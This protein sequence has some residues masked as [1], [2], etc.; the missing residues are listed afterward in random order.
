MA[1]YIID[2]GKLTV[3]PSE[4]KK[5][6]FQKGAFNDGYQ[7]GD[8]TKSALSTAADVGVN[9][10][11]GV[12]GLVEGLVD[13][14]AYGV[15]GAADFFG[16][17][18]FAK[19]VKKEAQANSTE[20]LFG[21]IDKKLNK[22]SVLGYYVDAVTEGVGQIGGIMLTGGLGSAAG[23]SG[24]GLSALTAGVMGASSAGA[25]ISEAYQSGAKDKEAFKY[26]LIKGAVDSGTELIFGGIMKPLKI[27]GIGKGL[28]S[29]DDAVARKIS[30]AVTKKLKSETAQRWLG[31][32]VQHAIKAGAEGV[33]EVLAGIGTAYAK[34][35]SYMKKEDIDKLIKDENLFEQFIVGSLTSAISQTGDV[36]RYNRQGRDYVTGLTA[37]EQKVVDKEVENRIAEAKENGKKVNK[38]KIYDRVMTDLDRGYI[39]TDT[40]EEVLGGEEYKTSKTNA[41][42]RKRQI[43]ALSAQIED[44][45]D[46]IN[47][48]PEESEANTLRGKLSI[49]RKQLEKLK[50]ADEDYSERDAISNKVYSLVQN[51]RLGESYRESARKAEHYT[52]D[53]SKYTDAEQKIVQKAIDSGILNNSNR[54]H[55][56]VDFVAKVSAQ[57]GIDFDFAD[58]KKIASSGFAVNGATINGY[59][60]GNNITVNVNSAK[61]LDTVV[62]HEITH[63][64]E[65]TEL[66][67]SLK[68]TITEYAKS[69]G[70]YDS[71]LE[72]IREL[73]KDV[74][75]ADI[76][77]ELTADLIGEY[78]FTDED[79]INRLA[80]NRNLFQKVFDEIKYLARIATAGSSEAK[81]LEKAKVLF[82]KAYNKTND[83]VPKT[84]SGTK[85]SLKA[86]EVNG[87]EHIINPFSITKEDV[88]D[89]LTKSKNRRFDE[90]SYFPISA[91]TPMAI[92][93][94]LQNAGIDVADKPLIMQAKKVKQSTGEKKTSTT[95]DGTVIRYHALSPEEVLEVVDKLNDPKI[96]IYQTNRTKTFTE[97]GQT[98]KLP[99]PD[100]FAFFV[101][102]DN[103]KEC[104]AIIEFDSYIEKDFI[105]EDDNGE[106]FHTTVTIFEPDV[107]RNGEE[108]D[109]AEYLLMNYNNHEL[110]IVKESPNPE[111]AYGETLA[112]VS[113]NELSDNT[114]PQ[115]NKKVNTQMSLSSENIAPVG[116]YTSDAI[117]YNPYSFIPKTE[118]ITDRDTADQLEKSNLPDSMKRSLWSYFKEG[119]LDKGMV[120][121]TL[122]KK[123]GNRELE[124]KWHA[125]RLAGS[126]AQAFMQNG[127]DGVKSLDDIRKEV[128]DS[129][130]ESDFE[131]YMTHL[132]NSDRMSL[133]RVYGG[134]NKGVFGREYTAQQSMNIAEGLEK[135]HPEFK[136]YA[137]DVYDYLT[138]LRNMMVKDGIITEQTAEKWAEMYPHYIPIKRDL[139][140]S[141]AFIEDTKHVKVSGPQRAKGGDQKLEPMFNT[142][143]EHTQKIFSDVA[144]N[145]FGIELMDTVLMAD[146][147][148]IVSQEPTL[149]EII[150]IGT[151]VR[152]LDRHNVG[153]VES[154][155]PVTQKYKVFFENQNGNTATVELDANLIKY[156][157]D[158]EENNNVDAVVNDLVKDMDT[159]KSFLKEGVN[160][161]MPTFTIY[162]EG[163]K[164]EF[165]IT[166]EMYDALKPTRE[167]Y[168]KQIKTAEFANNV[169]R[170]LVTSWNPVFGITNAIKDVQDV[171]LNS[172]HAVATYKSIPE[173]VIQIVTKKGNYIEE[174]LAHGGEGQQLYDR[175][176]ATF[177]QTS[178]TWFNKLV[179]FVASINDG[180]EMAPRLAEYIASR[181]AGRSIDT[182]MLD[183][184]RVTTN[185]QA[186]ADLTKFLNRNGATFLNASVQG[187][188]QN[189]RNVREAHEQGFKGYVK[190]ISKASL[191]G[192][193]ALAINNL[194]WEDDEDY[195]ELA[196]YIKDGYYIIG[197]YGDGKFIRI[198]KGRTVGVIQN[199]FMQVSDSLT[200]NDELDFER[201]FELF[202]NNIAPN[203][204]IESNLAA[205]II[206]AVSNKAWHGGDIIPQRLQDVPEGEQFDETTDKFSVWLGSN[207]GISPYKINYVLDQ[208][209]GVISDIVLPL[210]TP[211]AETGSD[212]LPGKILAPLADKFITDS[213]M[214]NKTQ[215][216]FY[217]IMDELAKK[218]NSKKATDEDVLKSKF[219]NSV[220]EDISKL[221]AEK[222]KIQGSDLPDSEKTKL[223]KELQKQI[224]EMSKS[225]IANK[226]NVDIFGSYAVAGGKEYHLD[227]NNNWIKVSDKQKEKQDKVTNALGISPS[228]Y[229]SNKTMYDDAYDT[230][231]KY[232]VS[233]AFSFDYG[234]YTE[235]L[236]NINKVEGNK[237][238]NGNTIS[239]S[240]KK[241]VISHIESLPLSKMDK[242]ILFKYTYKSDKTYNKQI[243][244][245]LRERTDIP[246]AERVDILTGLG[247]EV[248]DGVVRW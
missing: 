82:K 30:T 139:D 132:L 9:I 64:L 47:V 95:K 4:Q 206:Q 7:F 161:G 234:M 12:F 106:S 143:A 128:V 214:K 58:N 150:P 6:F 23:L 21:G 111:T 209:G 77:K 223:V 32:A 101:S 123:T 147:S 74:K 196:D 166:P 38:S 155:D 17:D 179:Q 224:N 203:N 134:K 157:P 110:D 99:A 220:N 107:T 204:P 138:Y 239:G 200:G 137:Q 213:V 125:I 54:T 177:L 2:K 112:T 215:G 243:I 18:N 192:I 45:Q 180:I 10:G 81:Q 46:K 178:E 245:Y 193:V 31:N 39:S 109:Y 217:D 73:Y 72:S 198:P 184:A 212:T 205:P 60:S 199:A 152:A 70:I 119:V 186:G 176:S 104:V 124:A 102:L 127:A 94:T 35:L 61:S 145:R 126:K 174:Y 133:A 144:R 195:Q 183:A 182:S 55:D 241:N 5:T 169:F 153:T 25:G 151:K 20:L 115:P 67:D 68:N 40:I 26:G 103:G 33:E 231:E 162:D 218:A 228:E 105:I 121:E 78:V 69:K 141:E 3:I 244:Q 221:S 79:F 225:A 15:A 76:E 168:R 13:L 148:S 149:G 96:A 8:V 211:Q 175:Q 52:A 227:D 88:L 154:Y 22:N 117:A 130:L 42:N 63:V 80:S 57:K 156:I 90:K 167:L 19:A 188:V 146:V 56:F 248:K 14:G 91:H 232:A 236:K 164:I 163:R 29:I 113:E 208:Y 185:F 100:N 202:M 230:P 120:F 118:K 181:K 28:T 222:R 11:K 37:D 27:L 66:Y 159:D 219:I 92:I 246:Y 50:K 86:V 201:F 242:I 171:L 187:L 108:F 85:F 43:E 122:A 114:I 24:A 71:K 48:S 116:K 216:D 135:L 197:K 89:Y 191:A 44:I 160:G 189:V 240:V 207:L 75:D 41:D 62:G 172:Q 226:D 97:D 229:W 49:S 16:A 53:M 190:L 83:F 84:I 51:S 36:I 136:A 131:M 194:L 65:G 210:W 87:T 98:K 235:F 173:A 34:K 247:F 140:T 238:A 59:V 93:N 237:D 129:G 142:I 165:T 170:N 158:T 233:K 1:N